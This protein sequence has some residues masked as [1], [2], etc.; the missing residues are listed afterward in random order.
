MKKLLQAAVLVSMATS[1]I[2]AAATSRHSRANA[3]LP[4]EW[5]GKVILPA[6]SFA[7]LQSIKLSNTIKK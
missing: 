2:I 5:E 7:G 3:G 1:A 6:D 4:Y